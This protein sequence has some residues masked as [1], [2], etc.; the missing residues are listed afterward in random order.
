MEQN[1]LGVITDKETPFGR[2]LGKILF[3]AILIAL[4]WSPLWFGTPQ[5]ISL[6]K[7]LVER[8]IDFFPENA[9]FADLVSNAYVALFQYSY[10][11]RNLVYLLFFIGVAAVLS[12]VSKCRVLKKNHNVTYIGLGWAFLMLAIMASFKTAKLPIAKD[13][14][15]GAVFV[16]YGA[17]FYASAIAALTSKRRHV[18]A[19]V[20]CLGMLFVAQNAFFQLMGGLA[21]TRE[22]FAQEN[23]FSSFAAYTNEW[24]K[25]SHDAAD[26]Y[27]MNRL[28][29]PRISATF[30]SPNILASYAM[31]V[32]L[33]SLGLWKTKDEKILRFIGI[34]TALVSLAVLFFTRSKSVIV[35]TFVLTLI[36]SFVL[37]RAKEVSLNFL[38][39]VFI[40]GSVFTTLGFVWGYGSNLGKKLSSS[41]EARLA[42]WKVAFNMV[43]QKA[44]T[45]Y[46]MNT[47][48]RYCKTMA[49]NSEPSKFVH[50]AILNMWAELGMFA[51]LGWL[52][53]CG[54]PITNGWDNFK[55]SVKKDA[56]QLSCILA[57]GGFFIHNLLDF[58]FYVP[59][60]TVT[61]LA[62]MALA[63]CGHDDPKETQN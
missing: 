38:I 28:L 56:L 7:T 35:L 27:N 26:T 29:S 21:K 53:A 60:V 25:T 30:T 31:I 47:F 42:Y 8:S 12:L 51:A 32:F 63:I 41:G 16:L 49:P 10:P 15:G 59:G 40:V 24:F 62:V 33:V 1:S 34:F 9:A 4:F 58:D 18:I 45:G 19:A 6:Q 13:P 22:L 23:G 2:V 36:W 43:K 37:F 5:N 57:S 52:L 44:L 17:F 46:G 50:N 11:N 14:W 20:I 3:I 61:A 48:E 39:S 55:A 54:L